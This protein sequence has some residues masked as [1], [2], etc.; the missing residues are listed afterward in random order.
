MGYCVVCGYKNDDDA[1]YCVDCGVE[2]SVSIAVDGKTP[3]EDADKKTD[4]SVHKTTGRKV[5]KRKTGDMAT[6]DNDL[7]EKE[8]ETEMPFL[9]PENTNE[10]EHFNEQGE[11]T[12]EQIDRYIPSM[13]TGTTTY[14]PPAYHYPETEGYDY[15]KPIST[16][17]YFWLKVLF[18]LPGIGFIVAVILAAAASNI[19]LKRFS[20]A[21]LIYQILIFIFLLIIALSA[22]ILIQ[23]FGWPWRYGRWWS[24]NQL[25]TFFDKYPG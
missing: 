21:T 6:G 1:I 23:Q 11:K 16:A 17:A 22:V 3:I 14:R 9:Q 19:N 15:S 25:F 5:Q 24:D 18:A 4:P 7:A 13:V 20:R 2:M 10:P 8:V 12:P